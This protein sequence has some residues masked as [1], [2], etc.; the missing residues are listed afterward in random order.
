[1]VDEPEI[2]AVSRDDDGS[3]FWSLAG[4]FVADAGGGRRPLHPVGR[5]MSPT[6]RPITFNLGRAAIGDEASEEA[7]TNR[8]STAA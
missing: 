8:G 5:I 3:R 7:P 4:S 6:V 1:M 2:P